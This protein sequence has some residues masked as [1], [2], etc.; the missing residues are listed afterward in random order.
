MEQ[1]PRYVSWLG[2]E[3]ANFW[4]NRMTLQLAEPPSQGFILSFKGDAIFRIN[5]F[6]LP[7]C[8]DHY[9]EMITLALF[10]PSFWWAY[11]ISHSDIH[12]SVSLPY[13]PAVF[14]SHSLPF[15]D[16]GHFLCLSFLH[17]IIGMTSVR[18]KTLHV[19]AAF[20]RVWAKQMSGWAFRCWCHAAWAKISLP[21]HP[22][23]AVRTGVCSLTSLCFSFQWKCEDNSAPVSELFTLYLY[24]VFKFWCTYSSRAHLPLHQPL[25]RCSRDSPSPGQSLDLPVTIVMAW[26]PAHAAFLLTPS[27]ICGICPADA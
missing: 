15:L 2:M 16:M 24:Q 9:F 7:R 27:A 4:C 26:F 25:F 22:S 8:F 21:P 11:S 10:L 20:S 6:K 13:S 3:P 14:L 12:L 1:Q 23:P 18:R 5:F 19:D 17:A